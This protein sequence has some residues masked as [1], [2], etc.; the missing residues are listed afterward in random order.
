MQLILANA[1]LALTWIAVS[2]YVLLAGADFGGGVWDLIAG[3]GQRGKQQRSLIE[4]SL[5]PV[6]EA[7][8]VWL[9]FVIVLAWT[10][11][12]PAFAAIAS[13]LYIPLSLAAI[14]IIIRGSAFAFRKS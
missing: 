8:H 13:T 9:I 3:P 14:G 6:W 2:A 1:L 12:P 4:H 5:G 11:F 7:N 10:V